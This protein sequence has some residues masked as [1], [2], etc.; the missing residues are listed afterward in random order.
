MTSPGVA[1]TLRLQDAVIKFADL[2]TVVSGGKFSTNRKRAPARFPN[3]ATGD[4]T[5]ICRGYRG[6]CRCQGQLKV[7]AVS[8]VLKKNGWEAGSVLTLT[9]SQAVHC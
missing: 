4:I 5:V 2:R 1:L 9:S 3:S 6:G 8:P 7:M